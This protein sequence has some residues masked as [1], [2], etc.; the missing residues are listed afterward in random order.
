MLDVYRGTVGLKDGSG[1]VAT[2]SFDL[3]VACDGA[4][5]LARKAMADVPGFTFEK[6]SLTNFCTMIHFDQ[7]TEELDPSWL[8]VFNID[9]PVV[10]GAIN[11]DKGPSDP[12]WPGA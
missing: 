9:P 6:A 10:A 7:N 12:K 11:G 1:K 4:G 5:S 3:V 2:K 8:Y